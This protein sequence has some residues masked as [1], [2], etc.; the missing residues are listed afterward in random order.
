MPV[1]LS[2][3]AVT[4]HSKQ[5]QSVMKSFSLLLLLT[6]VSAGSQAQQPFTIKGTLTK[7]ATQGK[8]YIGYRLGDD[9]KRDSAELN[10]GVFTYTGRIDDATMVSLVLRPKVALPPQPG[11]RPD[12]LT[13]FIE[14]GTVTVKGTDSLKTAKVTGSATH[15]AFTKMNAAIKPANDKLEA[16]Y[17]QYDVAYKAKDEVKMKALDTEI[18][19]ISGGEMAE[20][21]KGF[22]MQHTSSPVALFALERMA[23]FDIDVAKTE[24][25][26]NVLADAQ[27]NSKTGKAFAA[28]MDIAR[29]TQVGKMAMDFSQNNTEGQPV[30]L[31]DFRG[32][33]VLVD[34]WASWCGPCRAENPNVVKAYN[35]Y[36]EKN[37][38]VLGVSLDRE[39]QK[40]KWL[41]AIAD[42]QLTWTQ[43]SDLKFWKNEVAVLYGV[44]G[45]PQN[46]LVGPD[47]V[48]VA[49]NLR[50]DKLN[51]ELK[52]LFG[53]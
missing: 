25:V 29:K 22:I 18:E 14:P 33:Y 48:I 7:P 28:K 35:K 26:W 46:F 4:S 45:I 50:E 38:T 52:K 39:G 8:I 12:M 44:Q 2:G 1:Q 40:D 47:G 16:L 15:D 32:K 41:K 9:Y 36:K 13:V 51:D 42:D 5:I 24:P 49:R 10:K 3:I 19:A 53:E 20:A 27:K 43:V 30:K 37:F 6:A 11:M 34:F 31:S 23:G 21:Y 17:K